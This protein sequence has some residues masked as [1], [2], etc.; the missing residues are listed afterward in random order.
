VSLVVTSK[1]EKDT[2]LTWLLRSA[3]NLLV[4]FAVSLKHKLR[5]EPYTGY[6]DLQYL[7]SHLDTFAGAATR[8]DP[9]RANE[10]PRPNFFKSTGE[11]LGVS[12]AAS[13]PR[14]VLK[15]AK[16]P[17]GNLPLEI[18]TYLA[19]FTDELIENGQLSIPMQQTL[20]CKPASLIPLEK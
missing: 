16:Q 14:K 9:E 6:E 2:S 15:K 3:L 8:A 17:L 5:F 13:N 7:V 10:R 19:S 11:Y 20:A 18:L 12:F 1:P 4:A